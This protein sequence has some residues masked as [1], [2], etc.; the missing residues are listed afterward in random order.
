MDEDSKN[1]INCVQ[2]KIISSL[3]RTN[4]EMQHLAYA[5]LFTA[6]K[7]VREWLYSEL[8]GGL[9]IVIDYSRKSARFIMFD[10]MTYEIIFESELYKN[11]N[12]FY[13]KAKEKFQYFEINK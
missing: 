2:Y 10:L 13:V 9:T 8:E 12:K 1:N 5:K 7:E 4:Y 11:F 3:L 6:G